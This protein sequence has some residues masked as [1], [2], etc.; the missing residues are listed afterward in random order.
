MD[1]SSRKKINKEPQAL[2]NALGQLDLF[3]IYRAFNPKTIDFIFFS[4]A[5]VTFYR[6]YHI[7][8]HKSSLG[9]FFKTEIISSIFSDHNNIRLDINYRKN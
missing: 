2:N 6:R 4:S 1:R 7:L 3:H 5:H 8:G 9:K